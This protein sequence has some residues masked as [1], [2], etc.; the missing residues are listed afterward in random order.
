MRLYTIA[1]ERICVEKFELEDKQTNEIVKLTFTLAE[2]D[3][4]KTVYD[5]SSYLKK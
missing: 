5:I 4:N 3:E 2:T 1:H